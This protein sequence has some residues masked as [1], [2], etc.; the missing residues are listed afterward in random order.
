LS[1]E[2]P[3]KCKNYTACSSAGH[4]FDFVPYGIKSAD[5]TNRMTS[6][7]FAESVDAPAALSFIRR[8]LALVCCWMISAACRAALSFRET[9]AILFRLDWAIRSC[10]G[11]VS[12][13]GI[14]SDFSMN[15]LGCPSRSPSNFH[16]LRS[17]PDSSFQNLR[18]RVKPSAHNSSQ[19]V[20]SGATTRTRSRTSRRNRS[21]L[22]FRRV[23]HDFGTAGTCPV[24]AFVRHWLDSLVHLSITNRH[25]LADRYCA[26][27]ICPQTAVRVLHVE[28]CLFQESN[29]DLSR[30][31]DRIPRE[32]ML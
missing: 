21:R 32:P 5:Q 19:P 4:V 9:M 10:S 22:R 7:F 13:G 26:E 23:L 28:S 18:A 17:L 25:T 8:M 20:A 14:P 31:K 30:S 15:S 27:R 11:L 24:R 16:K 2:S 12:E 29:N 3:L 6:A 1:G